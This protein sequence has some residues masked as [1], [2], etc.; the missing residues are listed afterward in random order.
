M[1]AQAKQRL[2]VSAGNRLKEVP[3]EVIQVILSKSNRLENLRRFGADVALRAAV[4]AHMTRARLSQGILS[5]RRVI[6]KSLFDQ[7]F[8]NNVRSISYNIYADFGVL[9]FNSPFSVVASVN[10]EKSN[11]NTFNIVIYNA[12]RTKRN[13]KFRAVLNPMRN[14]EYI[15]QPSSDKALD[16]NIDI[17]SMLLLKKVLRHN[18]FR[19]GQINRNVSR[20][21]DSLVIT[22]GMPVNMKTML[23]I[24]PM[25]SEKL[26]KL[27]AASIARRLIMIKERRARRVIA[28]SLRRRQ[29]SRMYENK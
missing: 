22:K 15:I 16:W 28:A 17:S 8:V 10:I 20:L 29:I 7:I 27:I 4:K 14:D 18:K 1:S 3:A 5:T 21:C 19:R 2:N 6:K 11:N 25:N 26:K 9:S 23:Q 24:N 12:L 13:R